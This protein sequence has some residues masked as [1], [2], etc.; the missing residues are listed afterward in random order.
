MLDR[1][2]C[3]A[4]GGLGNDMARL[5]LLQENR[6]E[7]RRGERGCGRRD[8]E[9]AR[10]AQPHSRGRS[11]SAHWPPAARSP[12]RSSLTCRFSHRVSSVAYTLLVLHTVHS[13]IT[14]R[15]DQAAPAAQRGSTRRW[16][17]T[18]TR[19]RRASRRRRATAQSARACR[20]ARRPSRSRRRTC[21][22]VG[23]S[24]LRS[25][26]ATGAER[27]GGFKGRTSFK[28]ND[29]AGRERASATK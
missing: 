15:T 28:E 25:R 7:Q 26:A 21:R 20:P 18:S 4:M 2:R 22:G 23:P 9:L 19:S 27:G 24:Q 5:A 1:A 10:R 14:L 6:R 3:A 11:L 13:S 12:V 16:R 17:G 8:A 29:A